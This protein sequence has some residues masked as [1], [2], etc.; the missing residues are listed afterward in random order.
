[1]VFN[2]NVYIVSVCGHSFEL[3]VDEQMLWYIVLAE[4]LRN[5]TLLPSGLIL[6]QETDRKIDIHD[7]TVFTC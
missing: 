4:Q 5:N 3:T 6:K 1:M 2:N 7:D